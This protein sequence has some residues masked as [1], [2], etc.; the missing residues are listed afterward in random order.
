M[1]AQIDLIEADA[2]PD[3][4]DLWIYKYYLVFKISY[5]LKARA[6]I[7]NGSSFSLVGSSSMLAVLATILISA[8]NY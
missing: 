3:S 8:K 1:Q 6:C 7:L 4:L 5:D 2:P